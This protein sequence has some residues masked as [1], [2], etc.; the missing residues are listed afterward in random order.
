MTIVKI[1][2]LDDQAAALEAKAAAQGLSLGD[3]FRFMAYL[4]L[5]PRKGRYTLAELIQQC[6]PTA[7][8]SDED[9]EWMGSST[10]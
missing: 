5:R 8:L 2:L 6:G 9:R 1:E 10:D 3:W 4:E 7:K